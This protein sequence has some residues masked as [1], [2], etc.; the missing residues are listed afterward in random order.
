MLSKIGSC[1][2]GRNTQDEQEK[3]NQDTEDAR[4]GDKESGMRFGCFGGGM[5]D[6]D[7]LVHGVA[8]AAE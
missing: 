7:V 4:S 1:F 8:V 6:G 3:Q 2:T 5:M